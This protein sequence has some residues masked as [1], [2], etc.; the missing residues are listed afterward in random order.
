[1][2]VAGEERVD[3]SA[4]LA[5]LASVGEVDRLMVEGGGEIIFSLFAADLVDE[6]TLY[7]GSLVI[8]GRDAPTLADGEGFVEE[9]PRLDLTEVE[10]IDD[11][12]LL[13]YEVE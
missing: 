11:G 4:A 3:L 12:V 10:R 1:V 13:S 5:E 8:G 7:V 9:F 2:I 6:L